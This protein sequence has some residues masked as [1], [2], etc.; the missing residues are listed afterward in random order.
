MIVDSHVHLWDEAHTPQPW[1]TAETESIARPFGPDDLQ[2]LLA[3]NGVDAVVLVQGACLDSDTDYLCLEAARRPWIAAVTVWLRLDDPRRA[4]ER[5]GR[6]SSIGRRCAPSGTSSTTRPTRTGSCRRRS[7]SRSSCSSRPGCCSSC[8]SSI[9]AT[10]T[11]SYGS[12]NAFRASSWP[13]T[14]SGSRRWG[15]ATS[16]TGNDG[17][18]RAR[19]LPTSTRSCR[20]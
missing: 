13:S 8:R 10:S 6:S 16:G 7:S 3:R 1:M 12:P 5:L 17:S 9:R 4:R 14:T 20:G 15:A 2:P 18:E 11:T 19:R